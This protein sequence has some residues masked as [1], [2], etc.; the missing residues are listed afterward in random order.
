[1]RVL[2]AIGC[3]Y[4]VMAFTGLGVSPFHEPD[5]DTSWIDPWWL[6]GLVLGGFFAWKTVT[7]LVQRREGAA[8]WM[9]A[10]AAYLPISQIFRFLI[11]MGDRYLYF[12][13]PGLIGGVAFSVRD[14][15][16][17]LER[18]A[19]A[20]GVRLPDT[21]LL[22]RAAAVATALWAV[23]LGLLTSA[24]ARVWR[25]TSTISLAATTFSI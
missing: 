4:R 14:S 20:R 23:G 19:R 11:P 18:F 2:F 8:W 7:S 1:M 24:Q 10:A 25:S 15:W 21:Q 16:P 13:L 6:G 12:I 17:A 9:W 3:R 5:L 22:L